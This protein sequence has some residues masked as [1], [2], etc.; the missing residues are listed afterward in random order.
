MGFSDSSLRALLLRAKTEKRPAFDG[1]GALSLSDDALLLVFRCNRCHKGCFADKLA[2]Y[3][4]LCVKL[5]DVSAFVGQGCF[6]DQR[7]ARKHWFAEAGLVDTHEVD[8]ALLDIVVAVEH[9]DAAGLGH[10]FKNENA[11]HDRI[12]RKMALEKGFVDGDVFDRDNFF[13]KLKL[14]YLVDQKEGIAMGENLLNGVDVKN[15]AHFFLVLV[16]SGKFVA[17]GIFFKLFDEFHI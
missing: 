9:H 15:Y 14:D 12:S 10:G 17:V 3:I 7:V 11:R 13:V 5:A 16:L 4:S 6:N 8:D 1:P 2:S